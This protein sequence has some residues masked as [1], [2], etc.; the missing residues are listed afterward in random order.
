MK[1]MMY[2]M[3]IMFMVMLNNYSSGLTYYYFLANMITFSQMYFIK[4][5]INDED[6]LK[7]LE[8]SKK[9]VKKPSKFQQRIEE[10]AKQRGK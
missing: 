1:T 7:K 4:S 8:T 2:I 5:R 6:I 10:M 9:K 3:P